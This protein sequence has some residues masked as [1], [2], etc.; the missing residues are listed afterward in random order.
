MLRRVKKNS[1][2]ISQASTMFGFS[3]PS[4]YQAQSDFE[5]AGLSG[6][7]PQRR[8]PRAPHKLSDEVMNFIENVR[9][10]ESRVTTSNLIIRIKERFGIDVHRRTIERATVRAKKNRK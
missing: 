5:Q 3:R 9:L 4:F 8:G 2:S 1:W 6:F 7:I 10:N